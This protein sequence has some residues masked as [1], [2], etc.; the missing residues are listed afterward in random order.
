M[1]RFY[2]YV[3]WR[4]TSVSIYVF[5]FRVR[6]LDACCFSQTRVRLSS[7]R[8]RWQSR[9][10]RRTCGTYGILCGVCV[11]C[12][13][14]FSLREI[15]VVFW[16]LTISY[17]NSD[18]VIEASQTGERNKKEKKR[19]L[20]EEKNKSVIVVVDASTTK[21]KRTRRMTTATTVRTTRVPLRRPWENL[22]MFPRCRYAAS[23]CRACV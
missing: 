9:V 4:R 11:Y 14:F 21:T 18:K 23:V 12:F 13:S 5:S 17:S 20:K 16:H 2:V 10:Y 22:K 8:L 1:C 15:R 3:L 19:T 6:S 7:Y